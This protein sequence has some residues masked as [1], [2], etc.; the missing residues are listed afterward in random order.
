MSLVL[1]PLAGHKLIN[2]VPSQ[3]D[4][5]R[6][7]LFNKFCIELLLQLNLEATPHLRLIATTGGSGRNSSPVGQAASGE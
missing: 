4:K 2:N 6:I 5:L 7:L 1:N 3:H